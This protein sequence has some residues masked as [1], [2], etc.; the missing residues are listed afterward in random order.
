[1]KPLDFYHTYVHSL[2]EPL[3]SMTQRG[4]KFDTSKRA[5][6]RGEYERDFTQMQT[7]LNE[8]VGHELNI[9]SHKQM[10]KWLYEEL[11]LPKQTKKRKETGEETETANEE[12][13]R[14]LY[15]KKPVE[16]IGLVLE[17]REK[18][19]LL[20]TYLNVRI[21]DDKRIRCSYN[22]AGTETGRLSSSSTAFGTGTNLQNIP[23]GIIRSMFVADEGFTL[24]NADLSQAEARVVAY[25]SGDQRLIEVFERGGDIHRKNAANIY[26]CKEEEVTNE[27]RNLAKRV[28]HASNYGMGPRTFAQTAGIPEAEATK[29]LNRYFAT[30]PR[31]RLWHMQIKSQLDKTR[32]LTTPLGR[33]RIFFNRWSDSLLKEGLAF[34]PQSTVADIVNASLVDLYE[35]WKGNGVGKELLLQVHDSIL[36]QAKEECVEE[37]IKEIKEAMTRPIEIGGRTMVI[38][39]DVKVGKN[40]SDMTKAT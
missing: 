33:R 38:P 30:Y 19:K 27:Q 6:V 7:R 18:Q 11:K 22:I 24:I 14:N 37:A 36:A 29:L 26:G 13:L 40:W 32:V 9:G 8:L 12:A 16:E 20:S 5:L 23:D 25:I 34:V 21:D 10:T 17:M 28:V 35:R 3:F 4:V 31:I 39:V 2:V 1:M 15:K